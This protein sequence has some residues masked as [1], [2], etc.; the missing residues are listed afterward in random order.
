M[1]KEKISSKKN[2]LDYIQASRGAP[3]KPPQIIPLKT[4]KKPRDA[5]HKKRYNDEYN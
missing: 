3:I 5:K 2:Q 4:K 1:K